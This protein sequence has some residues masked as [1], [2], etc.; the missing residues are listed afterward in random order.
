MVRQANTADSVAISKLLADTWRVA[1]K[2]VFS[3]K[4]IQDLKDN[5]W[6]PFLQKSFTEGT[7]HILVSE[8]EGRIAGISM[9]GPSRDWENE[10]GI[11][12][13][14]SFYVHPDFWRKKVGS[15]LMVDTFEALKKE[16]FDRVDIWVLIENRRAIGF[17]E[18]MGFNIT[19]SKKDIIED[20]KV[21]PHQLMIY[22]FKE[23]E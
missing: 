20:E 12:E 10:D 2:D 19:E 4:F 18:K 11:G 9:Y 21:L 17:Y 1:F 14:L 23:N 3:K 16:G 22:E 8:I 5:R 6:L 7:S 13:I 15:Q